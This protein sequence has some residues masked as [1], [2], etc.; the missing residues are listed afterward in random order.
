MTEEESKKTSISPAS[1]KLP[2]GFTPKALSHGASTIGI[3]MTEEEAVLLAAM[4]VSVAHA[5]NADGEVVV[6]GH[7][8][9]GRLTVLRR[10]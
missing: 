4:L 3:R 2:G 9:E 8:K 1:V 7:L 10:V 5:K 6:T